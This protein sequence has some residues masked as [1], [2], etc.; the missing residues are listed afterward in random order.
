M[1]RHNLTLSSR[2]FVGLVGATLSEQDFRLLF[3]RSTPPHGG[4]L[5]NF[6]RHVAELRLPISRATVTHR[7]DHDDDLVSFEIGAVPFDDVVQDS[8]V[9]TDSCCISTNVLTRYFAGLDYRPLAKPHQS[10]LGKIPDPI[11]DFVQEMQ[12]NGRMLTGTEVI[13][14]GKQIRLIFGERDA[15]VSDFF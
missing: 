6:F 2:T 3:F 8:H 5:V 9:D 4:P 1:P 13:N 15:A 7:P 12:S 11:R 10:Y 14:Q